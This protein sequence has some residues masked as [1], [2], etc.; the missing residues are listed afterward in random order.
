MD[1]SSQYSFGNIGQCN[2]LALPIAPI[3]AAMYEAWPPYVRGYAAPVPAASL[4]C[5]WCSGAGSI[6]PLDNHPEG[7]S[8]LVLWLVGCPSLS[9]ARM[10]QR[11]PE[12]LLSCRV[13]LCSSEVIMVLQPCGIQWLQLKSRH[14]WWHQPCGV[15]LTEIQCLFGFEVY[16]FLKDPH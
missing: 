8:L 7:S 16:W 11:S 2:S 1:F 3:A 10:L 9:R 5:S 12:G 13:T 15:H 4:G 14:S 6:G